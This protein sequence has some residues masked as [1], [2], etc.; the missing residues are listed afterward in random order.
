[1]I[2]ALK[3]TVWWDSN[4]VELIYFPELIRLSH[5]GPGHAA[6]FVVQ[7]KEV[8]QCD[9]CQSLR[10]FFDANPFFCF[11]S[12]MKAVGP[13]AS[14]H[15]AASEL[16]NDDNIALL[17]NIIYIQFVQ[18]VSLQGIVD[19]VGPLHVARRVEAFNASKFFGLSDTGLSQAYRVF[20]FL[21]LEMSV[22][23][24][25]TSYLISS[26]VFRDVIVSRA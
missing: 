19:Q 17:Y 24:Q 2:K 23:L 26:C 5:C 1:M 20:F 22:C 10:F 21:N 7:L 8:L 16:I 18:I 15:K 12:L 6:E 25:L 11:D 14:R 3:D 9:C 13:L 4:N